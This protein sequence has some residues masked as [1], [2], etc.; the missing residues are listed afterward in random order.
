VNN[1]LC[2]Y[3]LDELYKT[4]ESI[5][6]EVVMGKAKDYSEYRYSCGVYRGLLTACNLIKETAERMEQ[7]DE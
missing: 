6:I 7:S 1:D 5:Q 4:G 2:K 3:L